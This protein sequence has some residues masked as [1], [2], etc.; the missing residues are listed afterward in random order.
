MTL[1]KT[2]IYIFGEDEEEKE[3]EVKSS[4]EE[5]DS[6][7]LETKSKILSSFTYKVNSTSC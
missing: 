4:K 7:V 2:Y 3:E 1:Y 6:S 5:E